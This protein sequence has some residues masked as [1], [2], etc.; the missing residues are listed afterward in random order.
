MTLKEKIYQLF[1]T[2]VQRV[3]QH[4]GIEEFFKKYPVGGY[5]FNQGDIEDV[6][7]LMN[8]KVNKTSEYIKRCR[9]LSK[10][11]LLFCADSAVIEKGPRQFSSTWSTVDD[12]E[13]HYNIGKSFG[14]Q[15][16]YNDIDV[17][18][19]PCIDM[20]FQRLSDLNSKT[21]VTTPDFNGRLHAQ[22][23]KGLQDM[24]IA[25]TAK[26]FPGQGTYHV[27]FHYGPGK[28]V[29]SYE[30]WMKTFGL[31]YKKVFEEDCMCVMTSHI[32]FPDYCYESE[33][34]FPPITTYSK[35]I[36]QGL[37]KG[38]LGFKGA[39]VTD[40]L[41]MGGMAIGDQ[42]KEA[43]QAFKCGADFLLCPP[44][45]AAEA[46]EKAILDGEIPM[47]RLE[48]A[49]ERTQ[50]VK[51]FVAKNK[52]KVNQEDIDFA[53]KTVWD[54]YTKSAQLLKNENNALPLKKEDK[55]LVIGNAPDDNRMVR[56]ELVC[57][58]LKKLGYN[59]TFQ[60]YLLTC[61][62]EEI[63]EI[64]DPYDKVI[65]VLNHPTALGEFQHCASTTWASHHVDK[66]KK[67]IFNG[68]LPFISEDYYPDEKCIVNTNLI[69]TPDTI[70][71][72]TKQLTDV[73][74]FIGK[75]DIKLDGLR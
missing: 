16:A 29:L 69:L 61:Y 22:V 50:R 54:S 66:K 23:V 42:V 51:D 20:V 34:G 46:I 35:K 2:D 41:I 37:L 24:G 3:N 1:I 64:V 13:Y 30:E 17:L 47:S 25:A 14:T 28:N 31:A 18:F 44:L 26:H 27:N 63:N 21:S 4:G 70:P 38:E 59:A 6:G 8:V 43:V 75:A 7:F 11:P 58:E 40:A 39:V 72:L 65:F 45:E 5:Y 60:K 74:S 52:K 49:L 71:T 68:V 33:D 62:Q 10:T 67:I 15:L 53:H 12:K 55:I 48:D 9:E 19:G 73:N 57:E 32:V 36:T 56:A